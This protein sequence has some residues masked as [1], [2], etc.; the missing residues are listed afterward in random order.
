MSKK[1]V[2]DDAWVHPLAKTPPSR[3]GNLWYIIA[4]DD[5][6]LDE[7]SLDN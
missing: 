7:K 6:N 1:I 5:R 3:V 2:V 4:N